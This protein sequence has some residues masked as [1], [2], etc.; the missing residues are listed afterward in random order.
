MNI[1]KNGAWSVVLRHTRTD[2]TSHSAARNGMAP[3]ARLVGLAKPAHFRR[4][5]RIQSSLSQ[6][7]RQS[8]VD[9]F[10]R[11]ERRLAHQG[12]PPALRLFA[13]ASSSAA[14]SASISSR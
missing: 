13:V 11:E 1:D 3:T 14:R 9:V 12:A 10:I 8:R 7:N 2:W 6:G 5:D 4:A